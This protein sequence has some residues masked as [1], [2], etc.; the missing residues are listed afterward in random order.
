MTEELNNICEFCSLE[1]L[2]QQFAAVNNSPE[3]T[4]MS[5]DT[6]IIW[7]IHILYLNIDVL[8]QLSGIHIW[9]RTDVVW[10]ILTSAYEDSSAVK[11]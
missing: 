1:S 7:K 11:Y 9:R 4:W 10:T 8:T 3:L 5:Q 6:Q 2:S